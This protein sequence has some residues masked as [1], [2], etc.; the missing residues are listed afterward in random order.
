MKRLIPFVRGNG[1]K[2]FLP[3]HGV[4]RAQG[5]QETNLQGDSDNA[6]CTRT[7]VFRGVVES[8]A[9]TAP[10]CVC[11]QAIWKQWHHE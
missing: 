6:F 1:R 3:Q 11:I 9:G 2:G 10:R 8:P 5:D 7:D 4:V